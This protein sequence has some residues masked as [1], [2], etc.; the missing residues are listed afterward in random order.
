MATRKMVPLANDTERHIS[1]LASDGTGAGQAIVQVDKILSQANMRLYRQTYS[2]P[3]SFKAVNSGTDAST[4]SYK[5]YTLPS[6]WFTMGAVRFAFRNWRN[7]IQDE[8]AAGQPTGGWV[9]FRM[10]MA[11][12]DGDNTNMVGA[13]FDGDGYNALDAG[14]YNTSVCAI[15]DGTDKGFNLFGA[16][17]DH[18]NIFNEYAKSLDGRKPDDMS[19][20]VATTYSGLSDADDTVREKLVEHYDSPPYPQ[21]LSGT[22]WADA[23]MVLKDVITFDGN[24][25]VSS[26][27]TG[28]FEAPLG[29]VY[30]VKTDDA[31]DT[32]LSTS[33]PELILRVKAGGY[34][35][36]AASP[37]VR[38]P[39]DLRLATARSNR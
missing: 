25:G 17:A 37:I 2:Y 5:F 14:E 28:T 7:G 18:F 30:I 19:S 36:V 23:T 34:K 27:T 3:V 31:S 21:D 24:A 9:D 16:L 1:L 26:V 32:D 20:T 29:L 38:F 4:L 15:D 8:L 39:R 12:A 10:D 13:T 6:N 33:V 22:E 35:G 11:N